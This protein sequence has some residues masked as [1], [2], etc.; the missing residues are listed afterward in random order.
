[1]AL[2]IAF[3][4]RAHVARWA[5]ATEESASIKKNAG[6][7]FGPSGIWVDVCSKD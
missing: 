4:T 5:T 1:V 3:Q 7:L 6:R 2:R